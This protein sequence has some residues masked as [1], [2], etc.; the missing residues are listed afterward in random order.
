MRVYEE[1]APGRHERHTPSDELPALGGRGRHA[2]H[3]PPDEQLG[4]RPEVPGALELK[5][6]LDSQELTYTQY[7]V[8][9]LALEGRAW[10]HAAI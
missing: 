4:A 10:P 1:P 5:A 6:R 2:R 8:A 3:T 9:L 7:R